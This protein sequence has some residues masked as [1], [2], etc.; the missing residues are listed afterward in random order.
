MCLFHV[1]CYDKIKYF[2]GKRAPRTKESFRKFHKRSKEKLVSVNLWY[3]IKIQNG[4]RHSFF[5]KD[6]ADSGF[7]HKINNFN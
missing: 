4:I 7:I 5:L 2:D 6:Q 1:D 3:H